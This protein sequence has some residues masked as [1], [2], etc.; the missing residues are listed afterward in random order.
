M[1]SLRSVSIALLLFTAVGLLA[2]H[3]L[4]PVTAD[5]QPGENEEWSVNENATIL[6]E[7]N[8][9][10]DA[11]WTISTTIQLEDDN[12]T[13]AFREIA[14]GFEAGHSNPLGHDSFEMAADLVNQHTDRRIEITNVSKTT[15]SE[16]EIEDGIGRLSLEFT[17][18]NFARSEGNQLFIDDVLVTDSGETW[19]DGLYETQ[20]L[21]IAAP[22]EYGVR[23]ANV[24]A[25]NGE[26]RWEGPQTF[27]ETSLQANFIGPGGTN[28]NG[29][30]GP[31]TGITALNPLLIGVIPLMALAIL[32][33]AFVARRKSLRIELPHFSNPTEPVDDEQ[34]GPEAETADSG[35]PVVTDK[36]G[37]PTDSN[38]GV[39]TGADS[40][41]EDGIDVE[42]LS[43]EERVER[44]LSSNGGRMKQADIVK[45]TD[46]SNAKVSQ[47]LSSMEEEGQIDKL[48]IG[49]ENL[50]SFPEE[51]IGEF[52]E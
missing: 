35:A 43:D 45:E 37:I 9:D 21:T 1:S 24:G 26:L 10:G 44:L 18:V 46:W 23:D 51:E 36:D 15:A 49:R 5:Q 4:T 25:Q 27:D 39:L 47:L 17:W 7:L 38:G 16:S 40:T 22:P 42:L 52:D 33:A 32:A 12:D 48:R 41:A 8:A 6:V 30:N 50:I 14:D 29:N 11:D 3:G 28:G 19:F 20:S 13:K 34:A 2:L 31:A